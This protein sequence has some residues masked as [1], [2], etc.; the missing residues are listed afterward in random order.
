MLFQTT[1]TGERRGDVGSCDT[2]HNSQLLGHDVYTRVGDV[3]RKK[4]IIVLLEST[5]G[6]R[7]RAYRERDREIDRYRL[8]TKTRLPRLHK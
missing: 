1:R 4:G 8:T 7:R 5:S 2:L 6:D 3:V